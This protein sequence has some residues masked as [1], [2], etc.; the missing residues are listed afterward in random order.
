MPAGICL[1]RA[2]MRP[3][4]GTASVPARIVLEWIRLRAVTAGRCEAAYRYRPVPV[5][6][7]WRQA[8]VSR[9]EPL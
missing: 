2:G 3:H 4:G 9:T 5:G 1:E 7:A 6:M 8:M